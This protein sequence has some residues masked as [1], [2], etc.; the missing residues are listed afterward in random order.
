MCISIKLKLSKYLTNYL[1][2]SKNQ[3]PSSKSNIPDQHR[4]LRILEVHHGVQ[5]RPPL[6][7]I[8]SQLNSVNIRPLNFFN[9]SFNIILLS[10]CKSSKWSLSFRFSHQN[11][12]YIPFLL[13]PMRVT[14]PAYFSSLSLSLISSFG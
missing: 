12:T 4:I 8:L 14:L 7:P 2:N 10:M 6:Y 13:S 9:I 11:S 3:G 5:K 1:T